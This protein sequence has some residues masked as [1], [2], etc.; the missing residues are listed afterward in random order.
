VPPGFGGSR[1][2]APLPPIRFP[3]VSGKNLAGEP[4]AFPKALA[5]KANLLF[6]MDSPQQ[7]IYLETWMPVVHRLQQK[8]TSDIAF[9][10]LAFL[11][12][13]GAAAPKTDAWPYV[14]SSRPALTPEEQQ[15]S[16]VP[17][18][19]DR[20]ALLAKLKIVDGGGLQAVLMS[21]DNELL[22]NDQGVRTNGKA[23]ELAIQTARSF[24]GDRNS[25]Q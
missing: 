11:P 19:G 8:Y 20:R 9:Y 13:A 16:V 22:W 1:V 24:S 12:P 18:Y 4:L 21:P 14:P 6:L 5:G 10:V 2:E 3:Q 25:D 17:L 7:E 23:N 15:K